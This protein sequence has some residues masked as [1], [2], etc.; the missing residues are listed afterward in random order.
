MVGI[1]SGIHTCV[2][3]PCGWTA[4]RRRRFS[5]MTMARSSCKILSASAA[6]VKIS[7]LGKS[8]GLKNIVT[9]ETLEGRLPPSHGRNWRNENIEE[10]VSFS[11]HLPPHSYAVFA[12]EPGRG[13]VSA[14]AK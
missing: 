7:T 2:A 13:N 9:G 8:T 5:R 14:S 6:D 11:A 1:G 4:R 10:R 3:F 12:L